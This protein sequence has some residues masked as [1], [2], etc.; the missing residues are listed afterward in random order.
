[1]AIRSKKKPLIR[2]SVTEYH[3]Y[4]EFLKDWFEFKR[5]DDSAFSMRQVAYQAKLSVAY[6]PTILA[7]KRALTEKGLNKLAPFLGLS[8][9]EIEFLHLL[10]QLS[11]T[12]E[13]GIRASLLERMQRRSEY[14]QKNPREAQTFR[15]LS[16]WYYVAIREMAVLKNFTNDPNWISARLYGQVSAIE[17]K[18][19]MDFLLQEKFLVANANGSFSHTDKDLRCEGEVFKVA[20]RHFHHEMSKIVFE[21]LDQSQKDAH[22]IEGHTMAI[23]LNRFDDART[24]LRTALAQIEK[25]GQSQGP[26]DSVV[27]ITVSAAPLTK[28]VAKT[29]EGERK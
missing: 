14:R 8:A 10:R 20:I 7:G 1:M 5:R 21:S 11:E 27:H 6:I 2:P 9:K 24:I 15:Y 3:D 28:P 19:A 12:K 23:P 22:H 13:P 16:R 18:Q 25:L 29:S 17:A 4:R 26:K